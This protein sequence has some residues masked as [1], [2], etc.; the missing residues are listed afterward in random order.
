MDGG[1]GPLQLLTF[2][3]TG[4]AA[5]LIGLSFV[6]YFQ[7]KMADQLFSIGSL[8]LIPAALGVAAYLV[9]IIGECLAERKSRP[10]NSR[11]SFK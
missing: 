6:S 11:S 10:V 9:T 1:Q 8:F 5:I 4:S 2:A 7:D 3:S